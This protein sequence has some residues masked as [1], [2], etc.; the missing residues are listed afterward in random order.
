MPDSWRA[1]PLWRFG[2][3][4][5]QVE[6]GFTN[7]RACRSGRKNLSCLPFGLALEEALE[8]IQEDEYVEV[9]PKA[10]RLRKIILDE[11]QRKR[12]ARVA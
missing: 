10:M 2:C 12:I 5:Y 11:T 3:E 6:I 8:Y 9:T 4:C 7:M 1:Q